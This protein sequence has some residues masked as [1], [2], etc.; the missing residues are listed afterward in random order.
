MKFD[1][2]R[3]LDGAGGSEVVTDD[4]DLSQY[5]H[6]GMFPFKAPVRLTAEAKSRAGV[7]SLSCTYRYTLDLVCDR[8]LAPF[9]KEVTQT[10]SH[11]VVRALQNPGDEDDEEY[12]L[13]P[14]GLVELTELATNDVIPELPSRTL[15]RE[16]C[17][18]LC[19]ICGCDRNKTQCQCQVR[20]EDPRLAALDKF[21]E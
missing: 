3:L 1:L 2:N 13:A 10:V 14:D 21:F 5:R 18:G 20:E 15:C 19:P 17:K 12:L 8:C 6:R 16:D 4:V 11:T 9:S 7:V